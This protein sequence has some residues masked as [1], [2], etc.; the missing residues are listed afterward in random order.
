MYVN[1]QFLFK[2][3]TRHCSAFVLLSTHP[4]TLA[5][6]GGSPMFPLVVHQPASPS[7]WPAVQSLLRGLSTNPGVTMWC[8]CG[9]SWRDYV[10]RVRECYVGLCVLGARCLICPGLVS[11]D[12]YFVV[13]P[14][15]PE[16]WWVLWYILVLCALFCWCICLACVLRVCELFGDTIR[17][18]F[19]CGCYFVAECYGCVKCGCWCSVG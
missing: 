17:N 1:K 18:V 8:V 2:Y 10:C 4:M 6:G 5:S 3:L 15:G 7:I 16:M 13:L 14:V 11:C 9:S 12:F 19:G